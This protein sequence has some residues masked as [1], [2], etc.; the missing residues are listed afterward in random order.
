MSSPATA[1]PVPITWILGDDSSPWMAGLHDRVVR[2]RPDLRTIR[3]SG[4]GHLAHLDRP[5]DFIA[6]VREAASPEHGATPA[7]PEDLDPTS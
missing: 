7:T 5:A 6:A 4:A 2:R 1:S 3:L